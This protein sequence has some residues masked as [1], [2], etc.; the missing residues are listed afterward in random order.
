MV[1]VSLPGLIVLFM[2]GT[3]EMISN[4]VKESMCGL[5]V[6]LIREHMLIILSMVLESTPQGLEG[7]LKVNMLE[8]I[9]R[10]RGNCYFLMGTS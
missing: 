1:W 7:L 5:M 10:G 6:Q 3:S 4:M 2:R 9:G 8:G